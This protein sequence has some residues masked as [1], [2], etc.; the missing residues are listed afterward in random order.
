MLLIYEEVSC[1]WLYHNDHEAQVY[2]PNDYM[3][4]LII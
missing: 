4:L 1:R 2:N 3:D